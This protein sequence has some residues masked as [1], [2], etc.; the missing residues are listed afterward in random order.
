MRAREEKQE[1]NIGV[2][3]HLP[4]SV[5]A[6]STVRDRLMHVETATDGLNRIEVVTEYGEVADADELRQRDSKSML[7]GGSLSP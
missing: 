2:D 5:L 3:T 1:N 7:R 6:R 4:A